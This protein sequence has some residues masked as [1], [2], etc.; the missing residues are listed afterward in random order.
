MY[1]FSGLAKNLLQFLKIV[2]LHIIFN[3]ANKAKWNIKHFMTMYSHFLVLIV[4]AV[5]SREY[6]VIKSILTLAF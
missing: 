5:K 3:I 6:G 2:C 1:G 4:R